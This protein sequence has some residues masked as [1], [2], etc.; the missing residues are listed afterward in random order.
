MYQNIKHGNATVLGTEEGWVIPGGRVVR[1]KTRA[2]MYA[3]R[4]ARLMNEMEGKK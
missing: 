1:D 4:M 2:R 3:R